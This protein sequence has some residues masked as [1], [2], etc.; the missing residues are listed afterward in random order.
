MNFL[1]RILPVK[2]R[3]VKRLHRKLALNRFAQLCKDSHHKPILIAEI[4]PRSP[5][6]GKLLVTDPLQILSAYE[7]GEADAISV[8]TDQ[9]FFGGN[10]ELFTKVRNST[11]LPLL[12]KEFI[13][14][15]SQVLESYTLEADA[16]L[17]I[18]Q[19]VSPKKLEKL[20]HFSESLG[21][22]PLVEIIT[23]RE[24]LIAIHAGAK[25]IGVNAR[26]LRTM[27][28]DQKKALKL[29]GKIPPTIQKF[30]F[31]GIENVQQIRQGLQAGANGFLIGTSLL[32]AD[33]PDEKLCE[34]NSAM[35]GK[36][37]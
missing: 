16:V 30:L 14:D 17:L 15:E 23:E 22:V 5:S 24:L 27:K 35:K 36:P 29:L 9:T 34:F 37:I 2:Q 20:I 32:Q 18:V 8:L 33:H 3:E 1:A 25:Y 31:S 6:T 19:L 12:R 13:I 10:R 7:K 4:K 11:K 21:L 26:N 28:I